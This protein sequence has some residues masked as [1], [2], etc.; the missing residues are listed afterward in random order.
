MVEELKEMFST[1]GG[2]HGEKVP[3]G[4]QW[5]QDHNCIAATFEE[6]L[7]VQAVVEA[8]RKSSESRQWTKVLVQAED[9]S[10]TDSS[11]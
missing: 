3:G 9:G 11:M 4:Q 2:F 8:L 10:S 6:A 7:Y 1:S 5:G